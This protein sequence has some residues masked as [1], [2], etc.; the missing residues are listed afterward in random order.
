M[1]SDRAEDPLVVTLT[2]LL[3]ILGV[4]ALRIGLRL[5]Y[6]L[7]SV[8]Y[9]GMALT[10]SIR[11][12][13]RGNDCSTLSALRGVACLVVGLYMTHS[14]GYPM[15]SFHQPDLVPEELVANINR[16]R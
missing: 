8:A 14:L 6:Q 13:S 7:W 1:R 11:R 5:D 15:S 3:T 12:T 4:M 16:F 9:L 10:A 2:C